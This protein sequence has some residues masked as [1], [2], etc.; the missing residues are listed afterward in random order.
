MKFMR[1]LDEFSKKSAYEIFT[2]I[3]GFIILK[4]RMLGGR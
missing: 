4:D 2:Q 3:L 1:I